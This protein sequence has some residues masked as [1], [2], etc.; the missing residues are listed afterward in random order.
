MRGA[1]VS[2]RTKFSSRVSVLLTATHPERICSSSELNAL[3]G[4]ILARMK[5]DGVSRR[6]L[7]KAAGS[8]GMMAGAAESALAFQRS[9]P[10]QHEV[11]TNSQ[12]T[13]PKYSIKFSV[14][15]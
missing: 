2:I 3:R 11:A 14:I 4:A 8:A 7:L 10:V 9:G 6:A 15:G 5:R 12:D 1:F 13:T